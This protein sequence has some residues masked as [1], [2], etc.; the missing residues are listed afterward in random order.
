MFPVWCYQIAELTQQN[1]K[2]YRNF[3]GYSEADNN[4][5]MFLQTAARNEVPS[6]SATVRCYTLE[7]SDRCK[8]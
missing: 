1:R 2:A 7:K 3:S 5:L 8:D 4:N 6:A